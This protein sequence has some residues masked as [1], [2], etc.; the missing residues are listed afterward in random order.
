MTVE[1]APNY[2]ETEKHRNGT[3][4]HVNLSKRM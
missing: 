3:E 1:L 2:T 4:L